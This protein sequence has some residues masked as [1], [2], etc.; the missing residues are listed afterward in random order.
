[1]GNLLAR[2]LIESGVYAGEPWFSSV[3]HYVG[4]CGPH[5]GTPEN[6]EYV[7]GDKG[8]L[9]I[10]P[11]DTKVLSANTDYPGPGYQCLP[12]QNYPGN[13]LSDVNTGFESFYNTTVATML[14][15][16]LT[17]LQ[18][19]IEMQA[20][21]GFS[22]VPPTVKYSL[23]AASGQ[24]TDEIVLYDHAVFQAPWTDNQGDGTIPLASANVYGA[25]VTPGSHIDVLKTYPFRV[26][27]FDILSTPC[28]ASAVPMA[29]AAQVRNAK[30]PKAKAPKAKA[31]TAAVAHEK[32]RHEELRDPKSLRPA[33][34]LGD[35]PGAAICLNKYVLAPNEPMDILLVPDL[36]TAAISGTL[37]I[38]SVKEPTAKP[39]IYR[40]QELAYKGPPIRFI[41]ASLA[42]PADP[43]GYQITVTGSQG[44]SQSTGVGFAVSATAKGRRPGGRRSRNR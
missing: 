15:L 6:L 43:G 11:A 7:A 18:A 28:P 1:M 19:A 16:N 3:C 27:L 10:T 32:A 25:Q 23:V 29:H 9:C 44:T 36:E 30:A 4:I 8:F 37:Q 41:R 40:Q 21:L 22:R 20:C 17:N 14:G 31:K 13:P 24:M 39:V 42:A 5:Y 12:F 34:T 33:Y 2:W 38:M 35:K 26:I